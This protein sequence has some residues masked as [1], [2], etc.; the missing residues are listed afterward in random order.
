M[1]PELQASVPGRCPGIYAE[2][3]Q[4]RDTMLWSTLM[5]P[6]NHADRRATPTA[7]FVTTSASR[8]SRLTTERGKSFE[9]G[10]CFPGGP[11]P[12]NDP[13]SQLPKND[14]MLSGYCVDFK[15]DAGET[16][17]TARAKARRLAAG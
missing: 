7:W 14:S 1:A 16:R 13:N 4:A 2:P 15:A 17:M 12:P 8:S 11:S 5:S 10:C 9:R 3:V 6:E